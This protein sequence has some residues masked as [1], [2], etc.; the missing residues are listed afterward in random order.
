MLAALLYGPN[1]LRVKQV[2]KPEINNNEILLK[3][4]AAAICGTD[5]RM[6]R[7]GYKGVDKENPRILGHELSG[8]VEEVGGNVKG[9]REGMA[10]A[11]APNMGCGICDECVSGNTQQCRDYQALGINLDGAFAEYVRIPEPAVRQG[12]VTELNS[13]VSFEE[14][15]LNEPLS[16]VYNGFLRCRVQ[17][18]DNVLIIGA[19]PIGLMHAKLAKMAGAAKV[20]IN[21]LSEERLAVCSR[22]DNSFQAL[23]TE[24]LK[25]QVM[26]LTNGK[27]LD[28]CITACPSPQ[29]QAASLE[30][31]ATGGRVNFFGGLPADREKVMLNTNLIHYK[32]LMIT[33]TARASL[34]QF[35]KTLDFIAEGLVD[36]K[37]LISTR[38]SLAKIE[39]AVQLAAG[40]NGLKNIISFV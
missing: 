17:P 19:G 35:R 36:V 29:A 27:G 40:A 16:C 33:G 30:L 18:G 39:E 9:Y 21:D 38:S 37:S 15:A 20:L 8:I 28:V 26:D 2:E 3:I 24:S 4:K 10:V 25:E 34:S 32:Q 5:L 1:D 22:I 12:N 31:M 6:I 23:K 13:K 7:N 14:A 11:V